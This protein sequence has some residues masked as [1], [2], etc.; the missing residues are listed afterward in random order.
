MKNEAIPE[1]R[2]WGGLFFTKCPAK[3]IIL[4][5]RRVGLCW[6][7][8]EG[9]VYEKREEAPDFSVYDREK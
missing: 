7:S 8:A 2:L 9:D 6:T 3:C 5:L 1:F 4:N